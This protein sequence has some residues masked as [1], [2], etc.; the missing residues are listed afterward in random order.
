[1]VSRDFTDSE[2]ETEP[3]PGPS[4]LAAASVAVDSDFDMEGTDDGAWSRASPQK[5][6]GD[7]NESHPLKVTI[8]PNTL[9]AIDTPLASAPQSPSTHRSH[10]ASPRQPA[11]LKVSSK[12]SM[13]ERA[14]YSSSE[15]DDDA[16]AGSAPSPKKKK[17]L[18][19]TSPSGSAP[20]SPSKGKQSIK[21]HLGTQNLAVPPQ[22][23]GAATTPGVQRKSYDWLQPSHAGA[24]HHG[25]PE[26][27]RS[28]PS[29]PTGK[30][31]SGAD[32][33]IGGLLDAVMEKNDKDKAESKPKKSHKKKSADAPPGPGKAWRKGIKK[34][35]QAQAAAA[36]AGGTG[37]A[38]GS[39]SPATTPLF[40]ST[41]MSREV[42]LNPLDDVSPQSSQSH[43]ATAPREQTAPLPPPRAPTPP[44]FIL[45]D[46]AKLGIP[47]FPNPIA[48]PKINLGGFPKV[49]QSFAP[50]NGGDTGP[51]PRKETVRKWDHAEKVLVGV[52]G[53]VLKFK[54]WARGPQS[55]LGRL[56]QEDKDAKDAVRLQKNKPT[57]IAPL[58]TADVSV[59]S[60]PS[61]TPAV[62]PGL[63]GTT[64]P[65]AAA[66]AER[67]GLNH[68]VSFE[69]G[70]SVTPGPEDDES[71]AGD[72]E[73]GDV[74]VTPPPAPAKGTAASGKKGKGRAP[75][76]KLAQEIMLSG[77]EGET[78][79]AAGTG[80][81]VKEAVV[82]ATPVGTPGP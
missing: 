22:P 64:D 36:A 66:K 34:T 62:T 78:A 4:G 26:R 10:S 2:P 71:D 82:E 42:S 35:L 19:S 76:S 15:E 69:K 80:G 3:Q 74:T 30:S 48:P 21:L 52:G 9:T 6:S 53:G 47:I 1:M 11:T 55:E 59:F 46:A 43:P 25:P 20:N 5:T 65:L 24:S 27:E 61:S 79:E 28:R 72:R 37:P 56:I 50:I 41:S 33:A 8:K 67:P 45:A 75:K 81:A 60:T 17:R 32:E 51:F 23:A 31:G 70:G 18:S 58:P 14:N 38:N 39:G 40:G 57:T 16:D 7:A 12:H 54:S 77:D 68:T 49:T 13:A 73:E 44:P 29:S 63:N